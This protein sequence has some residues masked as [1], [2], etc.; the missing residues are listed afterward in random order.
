MIRTNLEKCSRAIA[1][2][3]LTAGLSLGS[4]S[5]VS[6]GTLDDLRD[7]GYATVAVANEPPYSDV[8]GDGYVTGAAPD[9]ATSA[10][11]KPSAPAVAP[12]AE[13][14]VPAAVAPV[15]MPTPFVADALMR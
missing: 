5:T 2:T 12:P 4:V 8:K 14:V 3:A 7:Q 10:I 1:L 15:A 13:S 11:P 6:A 9:V